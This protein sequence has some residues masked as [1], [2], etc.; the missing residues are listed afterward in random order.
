MTF[1][2]FWVYWIAFRGK[3]GICSKDMAHTTSGRGQ[4]LDTVCVDH[5]H[6]TGKVR[7][8]LCSACNKGLG[9]FSDSIENL[10]KAKRYLENA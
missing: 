4:N 8:L 5:D 2:D 6:K 1:D 9:L 3:C 10:E 7:G